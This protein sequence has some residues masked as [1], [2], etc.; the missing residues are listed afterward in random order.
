[1]GCADPNNR[2]IPCFSHM[3]AV[4]V[5]HLSTESQNSPAIM[6]LVVKKIWL[7]GTTVAVL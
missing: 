6:A 4:G 5:E 1:M 7:M 3:R 2:R